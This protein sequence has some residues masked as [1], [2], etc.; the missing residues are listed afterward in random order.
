MKEEVPPSVKVKIMRNQEEDV[1]RLLRKI[2]DEN[3]YTLCDLSRK[4][5]FQVTTIERWLRTNRINKIYAKVV[6]D[7]LRNL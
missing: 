1:I 4:L 7:R 6:F 5:D 3:G 2:K